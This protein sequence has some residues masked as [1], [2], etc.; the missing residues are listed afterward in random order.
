[1]QFE[2]CMCIE[3]LMAMDR[4]SMERVGMCSDTCVDAKEDL[5]PAVA[6]VR[7]DI[8]RA[9]RGLSPESA[10]LVRVDIEE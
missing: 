2:K 9:A 4:D 10:R 5:L 6:E 3:G 8:E 1:M 7:A